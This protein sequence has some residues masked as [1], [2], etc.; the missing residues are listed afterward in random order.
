MKPRY[1]WRCDGARVDEITFVYFAIIIPLV[2]LVVMLLAL[3]FCAK[4]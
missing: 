4:A 2:A 1:R 3:P